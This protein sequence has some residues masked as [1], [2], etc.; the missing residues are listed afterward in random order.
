MYKFNKTVNKIQKDAEI[1]R[2]AVAS[3]GKRMH[4]FSEQRATGYDAQADP[5]S[6]RAD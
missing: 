3:S 2:L 4:I 1:V 5:C 6:P